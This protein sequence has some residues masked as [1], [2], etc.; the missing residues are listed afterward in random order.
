MERSRNVQ[1]EPEHGGN[2]CDETEEEQAC[3]MQSCD[4]DCKLSE[5]SDWSTCSKACDVGSFRRTKEVLEPARGNG[6]CP[7]ADDEGKRLEFDP[8]NEFDCNQL[9]PE[10]RS[11]LE[12]KSKV[13]LIILLDGSGSLGEYGWSQ[14][15]LMV[16]KL[17]SDLQGGS[18]LVKVSLEVFSGPKTWEDYEKCTD[19]L[20]AGETLDMKEQCGIEWI[21]HYTT[22]M[23]ALASEVLQLPFPAATTLTSVAIGQ[24]ESELVNGRE[25]ANS[26]VVLITDG[27][28]MNGVATKDAAKQLQEK[29]RLVFVPVGGDAPEELIQEVASKPY[30]DHIISISSFFQMTSPVFLNKI[31][32][33]SC[34][35]S[36]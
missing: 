18:D 1:V 14:S 12:C 7:A 10:N 23:G 35:I 34:P 2:P 19:E 31:I 32:S 5:W 15:R 20:P 36:G 9:L 28:P 25:D 24:A 26:V 29:A 33:S 17:I 6:E 16:S 13:D 22:D 4:E 8:C 30:K 3:A 27:K 11:V 21:S